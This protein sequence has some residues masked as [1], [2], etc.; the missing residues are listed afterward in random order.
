[1]TDPN[2]ESLLA[3]IRIV[4]L[5]VLDYSA[6][7]ALQHSTTLLLRSVKVLSIIVS[8]SNYVQLQHPRAHSQEKIHLTPH[9]DRPSPTARISLSSPNLVA[10]TYRNYSHHNHIIPDVTL[11]NNPK[12]KTVSGT[13]PLPSRHKTT[14]Q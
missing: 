6:S 9:S 10:A 5:A 12:L 4:Y 1:M 8:K 14:N 2:L 13:I 11:C 7:Q 3:A